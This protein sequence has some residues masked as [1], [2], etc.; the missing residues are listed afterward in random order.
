MNKAITA[1]IGRQA[2]AMDWD[3]RIFDTYRPYTREQMAEFLADAV[4]YHVKSGGRTN[5]FSYERDA[6]LTELGREGF[7]FTL[8][9][10][11]RFAADMA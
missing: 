3:N 8:A 5:R 2:D 11:D 4:T 6:E 7:V 1:E 10:L 9:D